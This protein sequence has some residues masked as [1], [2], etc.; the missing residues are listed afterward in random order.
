M[1][2][3]PTKHVE[4]EASPA[5][6]HIHMPAP[7]VIPL[8][9]AIGLAGAIVMITLSRMLLVLFLILFVVTTVIWIR[10]TVRDTNEL[11]LEHH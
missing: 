2:A 7:S 4:S 8:L 10:D 3:G 6:E 1:T 5:G 11:P 9:N